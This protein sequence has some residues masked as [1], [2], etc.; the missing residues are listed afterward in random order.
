MI[1]RLCGAFL[2]IAGCG[3]IG[4]L[5]VHRRQKDLILLRQM[6]RFIENITC[7][8]QYHMTALPQLLRNAES[9]LSGE[10]RQLIQCY[11]QELESQIAPNAACC[12][13]VAFS[14]CSQLPPNIKAVLQEIGNSFGKFDLQG[15]VRCLE[16]AQLYCKKE[17]A[18][19]EDRLPDYTRCCRAYSLGA[20]VILALIFI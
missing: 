19:R 9:E 14:R 3:G 20:G 16:A 12:M 18:H 4:L 15:Q 8:L 10:L 11:V 13:E 5:M 1:Y 2:L 7:D 6:D 17:L